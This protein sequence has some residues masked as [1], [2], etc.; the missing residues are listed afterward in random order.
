MALPQPKD[1]STDLSPG[2]IGYAFSNDGRFVAEAS[3]SDRVGVWNANNGQLIH[4]F[5]MPRW[6][7]CVAFSPDDK[8]LAAGSAYQGYTGRRGDSSPGPNKQGWLQVW[9][10]SAGRTVFPSEYFPINV[11]GVAFSPDG[12]LLAAGLGDYLA[13][14]AQSG[15]VRIWDT[16]TWQVVHN[17]RGHSGCVWAVAFSPCGKRLASAGGHRIEGTGEVKIWDMTTGQEVWTLP[18]TKGPVYGVAFSP[19]GRHLA[20]GSAL[21]A[22]MIWDGTALAETPERNAHNDYRKMVQDDASPL[23]REAY[24]LIQDG[25]T[26]VEKALRRDATEIQRLIQQLGSPK[27][28]ERQDADE[29]LQAIGEPAWWLLRK[30]ATANPDPQTRR[31]A[32]RIAGLIGARVFKQVL[33]FEPGKSGRL[34]C[35]RVAFVPNARRAL[36]AGGTLSLYD[37]GKDR[38]VYGILDDGSGDRLALAVS[39]DGRYFLT[40]HR[41]DG[42]VRLGEVVTGKEIRRF[43]G[44][45]ADVHVVALSPDERQAVSGGDDR[46]LRL[47]HVKTGKER[48]RIVSSTGNIKCAAFAPDGQHVLSGHY[49]EGSDNLIVFWDVESGKEVRRFAGHTRDVTAVVF[50]P[51]GQRFLSASLD[52]TLRLWS[53]PTGTEL[54]RLEHRG[55]VHDAAVSPDGRQVLSAGFGDKTIR[56]WDLVNGSELCHFEGHWA[57]VLGV[58]FAPDGS[59]ALSAS[60]DGTARLWRLPKQE[61]RAQDAFR[62]R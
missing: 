14:G 1:P 45:T 41:G 43:E 36:T 61:T 59:Q 5:P 24:A 32:E 13:G 34:A 33:R 12:K 56:L 28:E 26:I 16:V 15:T 20:T 11:W 55:G 7:S 18:G 6:A 60:A 62:A 57:A 58:A 17:L 35:N 39:K 29:R 50:L 47:W 42:V 10:V 27:F 53:V 19:D 40:S 3:G 4:S 48:R 8:L 21:G 49:A 52:G 44:H 38:E 51:D 23:L 9:E 37:L 46:T 31:Q 25:P 30:A 22:V 54:L 2:P